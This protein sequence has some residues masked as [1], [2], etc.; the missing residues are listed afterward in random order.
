MALAAR[1]SHIEESFYVWLMQNPDIPPCE[2]DYRFAPPSKWRFDI[3]WPAH[4]VAMEIEGALSAGR[5][6]QKISGFIKDCEKYE[7]AMVLGWR[8]YRVPGPWIVEF[9]CRIWRPQVMETLR[10]LLGVT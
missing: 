10:V 2:R 5:R 4:K 8:V 1:T 9:K 3:C 7:A 6:P